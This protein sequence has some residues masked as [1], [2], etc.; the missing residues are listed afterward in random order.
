MNRSG[1]DEL[2]EG[3]LGFESRPGRTPHRLLEP[4]RQGFQMYCRRCETLDIGPA[5]LLLG[6]THPVLPAADIDSSHIRPDHP[7]TLR[8]LF[9]FS[10]AMLKPPL[11]CE[12]W[13]EVAIELWNSKMRDVPLYGGSPLNDGRL[14]TR[15]T[16]EH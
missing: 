12:P 16:C 15:L 11:G 6:T 10:H 9:P 1:L 2:K 13:P 3:S 7:Q 5:W 8:L 4:V 14:G